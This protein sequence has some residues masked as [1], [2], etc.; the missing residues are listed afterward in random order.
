LLLVRNFAGGGFLFEMGL[1]FSRKA[2]DG[3]C[4]LLGHGAGCRSHWRRR[5]AR[6]LLLLVRRRKAPLI[7]RLGLRVMRRRVGIGVSVT[8]RCFCC[9]ELLR[10]R[11]AA[12]RNRGHLTVHEFPGAF[13]VQ[14][15]RVCFKEPRRDRILHDPLGLLVDID[16]RLVLRL[17]LRAI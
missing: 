1:G 2:V 7:A 13:V 3:G 8:Q 15:N 17:R 12:L 10:R 6:R 4:R 9:L 16:L 14:G 11:A 5:T